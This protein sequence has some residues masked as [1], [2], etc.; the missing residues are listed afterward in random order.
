MLLLGLAAII[1]CNALATF[2]LGYTCARWLN[3]RI[4][5]LELAVSEEL[6]HLVSGDPCRSATVLNAI[7]EQIGSAAG[8]SAKASFLADLA[9]AKRQE[10]SMV[11]E[12]QLSMLDQQAPGVGSALGT[13]GPN[14][15]GKLM[16]NPLVQ[17]AV[18]GLMSRAGSGNAAASG[19]GKDSDSVRDRLRNMQ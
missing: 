8:R 16:K 7:G 4:A 10:N 9:H 6:A 2:V 11:N 15:L 18:Q 19:N 1:I 3:G 17:L 12:A 5:R 14:R 13:L